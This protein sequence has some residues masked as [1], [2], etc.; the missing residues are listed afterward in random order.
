MH[1]DVVTYFSYL[2][3]EEF[4]LKLVPHPN[5]PAL[6]SDGVVQAHSAPIAGSFNYFK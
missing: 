6:Q 4:V 2:L 3:F 1:S 5:T